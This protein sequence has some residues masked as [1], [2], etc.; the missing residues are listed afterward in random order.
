[1]VAGSPSDGDGEGVERFP[2]HSDET[3]RIRFVKRYVSRDLLGPDD[4][5]M[6]S[7]IY[8]QS[9]KKRRAKV[10]A[11]KKTYSCR[12]ENQKCEQKEDGFSNYDIRSGDLLLDCEQST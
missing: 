8:N 3:E 5:R 1:M 4:R 2:Q 10:F 11:I 7:D 12:C 9:T 6:N